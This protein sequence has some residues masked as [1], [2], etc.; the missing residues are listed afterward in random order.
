[1]PFFSQGDLFSFYCSGM[2]DLP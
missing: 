2:K 1:M